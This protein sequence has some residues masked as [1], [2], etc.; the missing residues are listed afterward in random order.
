MCLPYFFY[1]FSQSLQENIG[2]I[3]DRNR[4]YFPRITPYSHLIPAADKASYVQL[5][6]KVSTG[7]FTTYAAVYKSAS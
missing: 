7:A 4:D 5:I 6:I 2:M 3:S 1:S